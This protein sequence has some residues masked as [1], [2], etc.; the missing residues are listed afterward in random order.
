MRDVLWLVAV[1]GCWTSATPPPTTPAPAPARAAVVSLDRIERIARACDP[2]A[3]LDWTFMTVRPITDVTFEVKV[4]A[5]STD[6]PPRTLLVGAAASTCNGAMIGTTAN[7]QDVDLAAIL[8]AARTCVPG[9]PPDATVGTI[10]FWRDPETAK[11]DRTR[12]R[13]VFDLAPDLGAAVRTFG[14]ELAAMV[15]VEPRV[16]VSPGLS[17]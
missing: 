6:G 1:T 2:D 14:D 12:I 11:T 7:A 8:T 4:P 5:A 10:A 3:T 9:L 17:M 16:C 15:Q 13:V